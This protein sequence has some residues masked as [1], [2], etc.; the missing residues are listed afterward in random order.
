MNW[1]NQKIKL[2]IIYEQIIIIE[3]EV[4]RREIQL[5]QRSATHQQSIKYWAFFW[6]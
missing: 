2:I 4:N 6:I 1:N 3:T 5:N